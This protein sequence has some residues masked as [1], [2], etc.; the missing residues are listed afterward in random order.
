MLYIFF[1]LFW[2]SILSTAYAMLQILVLVGIMV[3]IGDEGTCS[4]TAIFFFYV[5][6]TFVAAAILH[7]QVSNFLHLF[8]FVTEESVTLPRKPHLRLDIFIH[9][10]IRYVQI[11]NENMR[12]LTAIF[13][14]MLLH[15]L[16]LL[17]FSILHHWVCNFYVLL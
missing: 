4:P 8:L 16:W 10:K 15:H 12:S 5:A 6:A 2:A 17:Q 3:Q 13:V 11:C 1:Q 7:P 9:S 14:A